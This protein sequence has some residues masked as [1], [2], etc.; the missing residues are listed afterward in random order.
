MPAGRIRNMTR[1]SQTS[2]GL[3]PGKER[4]EK[5]LSAQKILLEEE[6]VVIPIYHYVQNIAVSPRVH[7][8]RVNP[9]GIVLFRDLS[10]S[11][12]SGGEKK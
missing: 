1:W 12:A 4:A 7:G 2:R 6:A 11:D 3:P 10:L 9:F 8:F 5:I